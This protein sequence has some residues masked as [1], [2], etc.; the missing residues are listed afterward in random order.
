MTSN[1]DSG[2]NTLRQAVADI[3]PGGTITFAPGLGPITLA[4]ELMI[5]KAMTITGNGPADTIIQGGPDP[6]PPVPGEVFLV[7]VAAAERDGGIHRDD[8]P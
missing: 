8:G 5:T 2:P 1:A 6:L 7:S 4:S 3:D